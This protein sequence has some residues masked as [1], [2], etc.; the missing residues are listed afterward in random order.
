[1]EENVT[2]LAAFGAGLLSFISPCVLP[3]I[4]GYLSYVSGLSLDEMR[5]TA[6]PAGAPAG[7]AVATVL[8]S[9]AR[10]Q[11]V[12][13][14]LAFILGFSLVFIALGA[15]ASA[16]GQ[17]LTAR[18][19]LL[20][21][22]AGAIIIVF[23]L[24]TMGVLRIEWLYQEKRVQTTQR[25]VGL[26]GAG[27]VGIAFAFGWTPCL[28]P[29]LAGIL[30][31]AATRDTVADGVQLLAVYSL[32]LGVP[33]LATALAIERFFAA[34]AK[35]RRHYHKI[36]IASGGLLV[37]IGVLIFTNRFTIIAQWLTPYLPVY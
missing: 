9:A 31:I 11:A 34:F 30:A 21:R 4:P 6:V 29:I 32:G 19:R 35:I 20:S 17:F 12:L 28:G 7:A 37:A 15:S 14:S 22:I 2:L 27:L 5:G 1:M 24:H 18:L 26:L 10:R 33:F 13:A 8:P 25:P 16:I 3:L 23:G 36:E